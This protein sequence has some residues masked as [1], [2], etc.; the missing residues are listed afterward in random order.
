MFPVVLNNLIV[1]TGRQDLV[2]YSRLQTTDSEFCGKD[3]GKA[4][5]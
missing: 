5:S 3:L 1:T 2:R 4:F